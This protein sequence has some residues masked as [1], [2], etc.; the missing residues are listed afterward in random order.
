MTIEK[1]RFTRRRFVKLAV[2]AGVIAATSPFENLIAFAEDKNIGGEIAF[3]VIQTISGKAMVNGAK[4]KEGAKVAIG[5]T[6]TTGKNSKAWII[7]ENSAIFMLRPLSSVKLAKATDENGNE[8]AKSAALGLTSGG[9][10]S[11]VHKAEKGTYPFS[12]RTPTATAGV[13]GTTFF[14]KVMDDQTS[15][16]CDCFG[17][18][19]ITSAA[20][21]KVIKNIEAVK[22][23]AYFIGS[24]GAT[25]D[26][27]MK[28]AGLIDHTDEDIAEM[29]KIF[30]SATGLVPLAEVQ[31]G[32]EKKKNQ[33][34]PDDGGY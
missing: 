26:E 34:S 14:V 1:D 29:K 32:S 20:N 30:A 13:R 7:L 3:G 21:P 27:L 33:I 6:L 23:T 24:E 2:S 8:L 17:N 31:Q 4:A 16:V 19:E 22:H 18:V 25:E 28:T 5:D 9:T 11:Y 10:L 15:Y 12:V